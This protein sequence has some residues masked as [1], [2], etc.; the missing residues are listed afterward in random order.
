MEGQKRKALRPSAAVDKDDPN[1]QMKKRSRSSRQESKTNYVEPSNHVKDVRDDD[2]D[3]EDEQEEME[4]DAGQ[5]EESDEEEMQ[6]TLDPDGRVAWGDGTG[7][8]FSFRSFPRAISLTSWQHAGIWSKLHSDCSK[9]FNARA[10]TQGQDYSSGF[11][12]FVPASAEPACG[13]EALALHIFNFHT[14][15]AEFDRDRSGAEWWTQV[16]GVDDDIGWHWDKDYGLEHND[17]NVCPHLATVTYLS[18]P[19]PP[20]EVEVEGL[21]P[22]AP[23]IILEHTPP[24]QHTEDH[25]GIIHAGYISW[26]QQGKHIS[27]DGRFLHGA[28]A[29]LGRTPQPKA[30]SEHS[31]K[32]K[33]TQINRQKE[34]KKK[35]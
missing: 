25:S 32:K 11:T 6:L 29:E 17:L 19:F 1:N 27:F 22:G 20:G 24:L 31:S 16:I 12:F 15:H 10:K 28:P 5:H 18:D 26:P 8:D 2:E 34:T 30:P 21:T 33:G 4:M 13:L 23:T 14:Q 35:Q 9:V 3:E 7:I